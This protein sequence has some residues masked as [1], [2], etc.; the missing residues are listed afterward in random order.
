MSEHSIHREGEIRGGWA[1]WLL[2]RRHGGDPKVRNAMLGVLLNALL[3]LGV[4][5]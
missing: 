4:S 1:Q 3:P 5:C 2:E